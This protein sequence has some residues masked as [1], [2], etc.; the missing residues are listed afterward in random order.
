LILKDLVLPAGTA[1]S[2][3]STKQNVNWKQVGAN[4]EV[5]LP[6]YDPNKIKAPYAY[7]IKIAGFGK[8]A[9]RPDI[10]TEYQQGGLDTYS[11]HYF[12]KQRN[13]SLYTGW[14]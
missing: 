4:I 14:N 11:K 3:L 2:F 1:I 5:E 10:K 13:D 12:K 8:F 9:S 6:M 7:V